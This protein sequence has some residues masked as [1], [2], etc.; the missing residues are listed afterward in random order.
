MSKQV[1]EPFILHN[2][3]TTGRTNM[4]TLIPAT[5]HSFTVYDASIPRQR[6]GMSAAVGAV[7]RRHGMGAI[8]SLGPGSQ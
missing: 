2:T 6:N 3:Q 5:I 7:V 1:R 4:Q 8:V